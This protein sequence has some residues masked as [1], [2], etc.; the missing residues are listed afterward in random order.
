M[1]GRSLF[2]LGVVHPRRKEFAHV[3]RLTTGYGADDAAQPPPS[4]VDRRWGRTGASA[5][6]PASAVIAAVAIIIVAVFNLNIPYFA[7]LPGPTQDVVKLIEVEGAKAKKVT[8]ELLLTTVSLH[9]IR[10][11]EAVRGWFDTSY[12]IV[13]RS[14]IIPEGNT[15]EEAE[16]RTIAQMDM[17]HRF[18]A[19][20]ALRYLGYDVKVTSPPARI[21]AVSAD[22][23]ARK[24]LRTGDVIVAVDSMP[25][26]GSDDFRPAVQRRKVGEVLSLRVKR[27]ND[28]LTVRTKTIARTAG[29]NEPIVGVILD[30]APRID[31]PLAIDIESLGIGGPSAGLMYALGI[32]EL[33]DHRD[34]TNDR[35]IAGTGEI[36]IDGKVG[37]VGGVRQKVLAA[38]RERADLFLVPR[39]ELRDACASADA[40]AVVGVDSLEEAVRALRDR[41]F[42]SER[43]C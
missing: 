13:S 25:V 34:L 30:E 29:S 32:V 22:A 42:V 18:A 39:A 21:L 38:Q 16:R 43:D 6:P 17:S 11:A 10:V 40:M 7:L 4:Q 31:L 27:G 37:A 20:A 19:A 15:E 14:A 9:E 5:V 35:T 28:V 41:R 26:D 1:V 8:G 24:V 12:A 36:A 23:P 2:A 33:L 3:A